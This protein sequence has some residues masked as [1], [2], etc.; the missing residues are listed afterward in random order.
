M[1][2]WALMCLPSICGFRLAFTGPLYDW[3]RG[4]ESGVLTIHRAFVSPKAYVLEYDSD[5]FGS[6]RW[7]RLPLPPPKRGP[8]YEVH[9]SQL[10][11][12]HVKGMTEVPVMDL[13]PHIAVDR[14]DSMKHQ[15]VEAFISSR[16]RQGLR[17]VYFHRSVNRLG[18]SSTVFAETQIYLPVNHPTYGT[19]EL[20]NNHPTRHYF[21]SR[22]VPMMVAAWPF[23]AAAD[24]ISA[25]LMLV[26][27]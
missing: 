1:I 25:P 2:V 4:G 7:A 20:F 8:Q 21:I 27:R 19:L 14:R 16:E 13:R 11:D 18:D 26:W 5:P 9:T 17:G 23:A 22:R 15:E 3:A 24:I 12:R 6:R 10:E